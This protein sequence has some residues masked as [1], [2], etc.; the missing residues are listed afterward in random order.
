MLTAAIGKAKSTD[1]L[2]VANALEGLHYNGAGGEAWIRAD[3]HQVIAPLYL[4][5]FVKAGGPGVKFDVED[6][7]YGWKPEGKVEAKDAVPEM[8]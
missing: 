6:T 7:G 8:K 1:P 2:K 4:A 5:S 3:D